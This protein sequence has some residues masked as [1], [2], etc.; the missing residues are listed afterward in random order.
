MPSYIEPPRLVPCIH[1]KHSIGFNRLSNME[2]SL[3]QQISGVGE[4]R[5]YV[6]RMMNVVPQWITDLQIMQPT[7]SREM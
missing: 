1:L 4:R 2:N 6:T 5:N 7:H 3:N